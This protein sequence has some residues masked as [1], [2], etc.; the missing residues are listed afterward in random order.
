M[1]QDTEKARIVVIGSVNMDL[2]ASTP[3]IPLAGETILGTRLRTIPGGKGANQAVAAARLGAD[4][5]F[6]G[7][8]GA[9]AFGRSLCD[10]LLAEHVDCTHLIVSKD[11]ASGVALIFVAADGQNAICVVAG[12]NGRVSPEDV[13]SARDRIAVAHVCLLQLEIPIST[14][15]HTARVCRDCGVPLL[16]DPAPAPADPLPQELR[17]VDVLSPNETE[18]AQLLGIAVG[19]PPERVARQLRQAGASRVVLK[20]G[21]AGAYVSAEGREDQIPAFAVDV[22]DTTAAGDAFSAAL[23]VSLAE[24]NDIAKAARWA[25]AAGAL[26][27]TRFGAQPALPT[28]GE[29]EALL[30]GAPRPA[31]S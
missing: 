25:S 26:T 4:V 2:V 29:V 19:Q 13:D 24:G 23:A 15:T 8:V 6:V 5:T 11:V 18:A 27:C 21:A 10:G 22:V 30:A 31:D 17:F 9:D 28:R 20:Q 14:A 12:A 16:L 1:I 7:R 3:R